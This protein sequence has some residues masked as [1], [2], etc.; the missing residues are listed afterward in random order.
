[1]S[2]FLDVGNVFE[3]YNTFDAGDLRYSVGLAG[4]WLSPMGPISL[5]LGFPLN[6]EDDDEIQNFQFTVGSFF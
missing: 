1:M 5:S 4:L 3:D 6:D 2:A